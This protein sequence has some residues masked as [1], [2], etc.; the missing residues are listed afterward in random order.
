MDQRYEAARAYV[1][2]HC[3]PEQA[4]AARAGLDAAQLMALEA[5][6]VVPEPTYRVGPS[7][8]ISAIRRLGEGEAGAAGWYGVSVTAWL[9]RAAVLAEA[10]PAAELAG[11]MA[12]GLARDLAAVLDGKAADARAFG[13][14]GLFRGERCD[15]AAARAYVDGEWAGWM[16]GGWAVCLRRFDGHSLAVK[17]IERQ[18]IAAMLA[19]GVATPAERLALTDAM[20]RLDAVLLP[21]APHERP[22]GTPGRFLDEPARRLELPWDA[23]YEAGT[24]GSSI[25]EAVSPVR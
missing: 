10:V 4:L 13:W 1:A 21:F 16:A 11:A 12:D 9:R 3:I 19:A 15:L 2:A 17:E 25:D 18:R 8:V 20:G 6:G 5:A 23:P 7:S 24:T 22:H 14:A